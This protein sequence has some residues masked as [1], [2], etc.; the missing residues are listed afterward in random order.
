[1]KPKI[2]AT[3]RHCGET[4]DP[5]VTSH[6]VTM[7]TEAPNGKWLWCKSEKKSKSVTAHFK[8]ILTNLFPELKN[9]KEDEFRNV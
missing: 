6:I 5:E 1:M 7:S 2:L 3:C 4:F 8:G 9:L